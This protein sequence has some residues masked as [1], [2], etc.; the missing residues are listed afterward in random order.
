LRGLYGNPLVYREVTGWQDFEP[1]LSR[2]E[3]AGADD[4]WACAQGLPEE[5]YEG[6]R[7]GLERLIES[8]YRRRLILRDL[9]TAF[10]NSSQ[11]PFP[12]WNT[13]AARIFFSKSFDDVPSQGYSV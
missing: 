5:W 2:A 3:Q 10:R 9:I 12:K 6:D 7:S 13:G 1:A 11:S 4:L 8:L